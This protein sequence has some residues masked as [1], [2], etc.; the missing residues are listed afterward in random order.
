MTDAATSG[1]PLLYPDN[2]YQ[3]EDASM[4]RNAVHFVT[5]RRAHAAATVLGQ[6]DDDDLNDQVLAFLTLQAYQERMTAT[7]DTLGWLFVLRDWVPGMVE[8]SLVFLLDR[9]KV[10]G[11]KHSEAEAIRLLDSLEPASLRSLLHLP[12]AEQLRGGGLPDEVVEMIDVSLPHQLDGLRGIADFR[13]ADKRARV[14]A[15]NKAKHMLVGGRSLK[16]GKHEIELITRLTLKP[17][18]VHIETLTLPIEVA[19]IQLN[20]SQAIQLQTV[21]NGML[22]MILWV[23]FG[24]PYETPPWAVKALG[25]PG[26]RD[27]GVAPATARS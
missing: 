3:Y 22:G 23:R 6:L 11:R 24:E 7:E 14:R 5:A 10:G 19:E 18:G 8:H 13:Q 20:A 1:A 9:V 21:L 15:F 4:L 27:D 25:L 12:P 17:D 2:G 16:R 26:W